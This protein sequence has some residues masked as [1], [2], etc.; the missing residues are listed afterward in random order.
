MG[1][2]ATQMAATSRP[3]RAGASSPLG[4]PPGSRPTLI[5]SVQR[6]LRL[7]EAVATSPGGAPAKQLARKAGLPLATAYHLLRTLTFEGYLQRLEDGSYVLGDEVARLLDAGELQVVRQ[8]VRP[9]L[10]ALR[11]EARAAAYFARYEDGEIVVKAI[12][13][14]PRYPR[15]DLWVGF[16]DAAHATALGRCVL[17]FLDHEAVQDYVS[18]HPLHALTSRTVTNTSTLFKLLDR[19]RSSGLAVED[20]EYLPGNACLATPVLAEGLVG[21]VALSFPQRRLRDLEELSGTL[22]TIAGRIARAHL[23]TI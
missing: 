22:R 3:I 9:A 18:R 19:V 7:L 2:G 12:E 17:A 20:G 23:L 11:D 8:R 16:R 10:T 15:I 13:D 4:G 6:A 21:A 5:S 14:S 1:T